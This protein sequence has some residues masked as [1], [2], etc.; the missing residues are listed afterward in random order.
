MAVL[1][2]RDMEETGTLEEKEAGTRDGESEDESGT[3]DAQS[4]I[5][6]WTSSIEWEIT[7]EVTLADA[8]GADLIL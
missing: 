7:S 2:E 8:D 6:L 1:N 4:S 3:G 5:F